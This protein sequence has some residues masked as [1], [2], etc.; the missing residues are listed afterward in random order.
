MGAAGEPA[1]IK[2]D[3]VTPNV[4]KVVATGGTLKFWINGVMVKTL[5]GQ[6]TYLTGKVGVGVVRTSGAP[7]D[8]LKVN[9]AKLSPAGF[10]LPKEEVLEGEVSAEQ[11]AANAEANRRQRRSDPLFDRARP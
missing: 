3:G 9:Y 6:T 7:N 11:E 5:T 10:A 4:L 2:T 8:V 1:L